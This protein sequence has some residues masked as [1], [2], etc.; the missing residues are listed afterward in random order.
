MSELRMGDAGRIV[1]HDIDIQRAVIDDMSVDEA[2]V[3]AGAA[4]QQ[5]IMRAA[6]RIIVPSLEESGRGADSR[7]GD[8]RHAGRIAGSCEKE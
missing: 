2:S 4:R 6:Q 3:A 8:F 1:R 7:D 5:V